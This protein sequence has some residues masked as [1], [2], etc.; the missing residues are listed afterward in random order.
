MSSWLCQMALLEASSEEGARERGREVTF[1]K[2]PLGPGTVLG[3]T[4]FPEVRL[5]RLAFGFICTKKLGLRAGEPCPGTAEEVEA[6]P[7][8]LPDFTPSPFSLHQDLPS[9]G[10]RTHLRVF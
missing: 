9:E 2:S 3:A 8:H 1:M 6:E 5:S 4:L 10:A 7:C